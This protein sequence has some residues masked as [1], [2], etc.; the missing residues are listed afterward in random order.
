MRWIILVFF[1]TLSAAVVH[2]QNDLLAQNYFEQGEYEKALAIFNKLL[3]KNPNR[4]DYF[5]SVVTTNQ[6][7]ENFEVSEKMLLDKINSGRIIPQL[8][9]ELGYNFSLQRNDSIAEKYYDEALEFISVNPNYAPMVGES[10]EKYSLLDQ[11]VSTYEAAMALSGHDY[12]TQLARLYGEQGD[13]DKMFSK[14]LDLI[15]NRPI[16]MSRA[17]GSFSLYINEDPNNQANISLRK[18]LLKKLQEEPNLIYNELLSWLFIQQ[19]DYKKAFS[20]EKAIYKRMEDGDLNSMFELALIAIANEHYDDASEIVNFIIENSSTPET[21]LEGHQYSM[22]IALK[23]A[24]EEDYQG[25]VER[26]DDLFDEYGRS[27]ETYLLQIDYNH[28]LAFSLDRKDE[29]I[30]NLRKLLKEPLNRHQMARV[31]MKLADILVYDETFNE[32]LIYYSQIQKDLKNDVLAQEARFKVA[33]TSYYKG[34]F[35]WAKIQLDVLKKSAS[36]LI[37]NDA[38]QLSLII[39]DNSL[40]DSTQTALKK[41]ARA[42]LLMHQKKNDEAIV[43]LKDILNQHKGEMIEDEALLKLGEIYENLSNYE[44]AESSY[45]KLI[46]FYGDDILADDAHYR[47]ARLYEKQLNEIEKAKE[48]YELIIFNFADSI[49]YVDAQK[50]YRSLRGDA[51]E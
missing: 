50:K 35:T 16:Y 22:Q 33:R 21:R 18:A 15:V 14:Y 9:V 20:Q 37:A 1:V 36:Q 12:N 6:Q 4:Y 3:E 44:L 38:M 51:I 19:M 41:Y 47:L 27:K 7:L 48:Y 32:A 8:Y 13:L 34:D 24:K 23:T 43:I 49:F 28:F 40:E 26:Y 39:Q 42:D 31:K 2:S 45:L 10:F 17:Q 46:E 5:M 11:A 30:S 25:I 29:A